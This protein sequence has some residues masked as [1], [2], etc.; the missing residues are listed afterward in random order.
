MFSEYFPTVLRA[1]LKVTVTI[2]LRN[3]RHILASWSPAVSDCQ[4]FINLAREKHPSEGG[5]WWFVFAW[6]REWHYLDVW[7]CWNR[8]GLV[9]VGVLK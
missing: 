7:P 8:C 1:V 9:G 4:G 2:L 5:I 6:P 3:T